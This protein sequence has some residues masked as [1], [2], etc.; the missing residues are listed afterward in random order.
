MSGVPKNIESRIK[1][2]AGARGLEV[3]KIQLEEE[4]ADMSVY[5]VTIEIEGGDN[6]DTFVERPNEPGGLNMF[7]ERLERTMS[8]LRKE[9][10]GIEDETDQEVREIEARLEQSGHPS[11]T[12]ERP[13]YGPGPVPNVEGVGK[14]YADEYVQ[15]RS[16]TEAELPEVPDYAYGEQED[17]VG[18]VSEASATEKTNDQ[19]QQQPDTTTMPQT[20]IDPDSIWGQMMLAIEDAEHLDSRGRDRAVRALLEEVVEDIEDYLD[21]DEETTPDA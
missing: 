17:N 8:A 19:T 10:L 1:S 12:G 3:A 18:S 9:L 16:T 6:V 21:E 4:D 2:A 14:G 11:A 5:R 15:T 13:T 20:N 7:G